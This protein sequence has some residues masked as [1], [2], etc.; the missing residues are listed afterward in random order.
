MLVSDRMKQPVQTISRDMAILEALRVMISFRIRQLPVLEDSRLV[1]IG[2]YEDH[3]Y[4]SPSHA[5]FLSIW[6]MNYLISKITVR[7]VMTEN[8]ITG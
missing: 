8:V 6:D 4:V 7:Q 5:T 2:T 1:V 3:I